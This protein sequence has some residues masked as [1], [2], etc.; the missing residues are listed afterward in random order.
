MDIEYF[1]TFGKPLLDESFIACDMGPIEMKT[2]IR[3][4][5]YGANSL[6]IPEEK[7]KLELNMQE[8]RLVNNMIDKLSNM[9]Y[10]D[11][12]DYILKKCGSYIMS[13]IKF[14]KH[15]I[16]KH[17]YESDLKMLK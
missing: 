16:D 14:E 5:H 4:R 6:N 13:Y 2:Y 9:K 12:S 1:K 8:I 7:A 15:V 17:K 3:F 11:M 10:W